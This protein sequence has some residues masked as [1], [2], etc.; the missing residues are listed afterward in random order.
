MR[1]YSSKFIKRYYTKENTYNNRT[2]EQSS[3]DFWSSVKKDLQKNEQL[4]ESL[5]GLKQSESLRNVSQSVEALRARA[6]EDLNRIVQKLDQSVSSVKE[7]LGSVKEKVEEVKIPESVTNATKATT[8]GATSAVTSLKGLFGKAAL[9]MVGIKDRFVSMAVWSHISSTALQTYRSTTAAL[10]RPLAAIKQPA[11]QLQEKIT[12]KAADTYGAAS[13]MV[14]S[15][16]ITKTVR[17]TV[18]KQIL[19]SDNPLVQRSVDAVILTKRRVT[20]TLFRET[21]RAKALAAM[22]G[23]NVALVHESDLTE[24]LAKS[25]L[26]MF[27]QA[28]VS[29]DLPVI[30][31]HSH[32]ALHD[33]CKSARDEY[34][35]AGLELDRPLLDVDDVDIVDMQLDDRPI[36]ND[37]GEAV[38]SDVPRVIIVI[39]CSAQFVHCIRNASTKAVVEGRPDKILKSTW[40]VVLSP[41][42]LPNPSAVDKK[43][44]FNVLEIMESQ[45]E[46]VLI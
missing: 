1:R 31:R 46:M 20:R 12:E 18:Q 44:W 43:D 19:D 40:M 35:A 28:F 25:F 13:D 15:S 4:Q 7:S 26:P 39:R 9:A 34:A 8:A 24:A 10:A 30:L 2:K 33:M 23:A 21:S 37:A 36:V 6:G 42:S 16:P 41:L 45:S 11:A 27:L 14:A 5:R 22:R 29:L 32:D 38:E 17:D 3:N